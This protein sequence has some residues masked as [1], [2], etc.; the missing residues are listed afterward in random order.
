MMAPQVMQ[1]GASPI[2]YMD[3]MA[4]AAWMKLRSGGRVRESGA[5]EFGASVPLRAARSGAIPCCGA[6]RS[7][8][9]K[10]SGIRDKGSARLVGWRAAVDGMTVLSGALTVPVTGM[11]WLPNSRAGAEADSSAS[12]R[13]DKAGAAALAPR[14]LRLKRESWWPERKRSCI[15]RKR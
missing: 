15:Q 13:N 6:R 11:D 14:D 3:F 8:N 2:S 7:L 12:L 1:E 4:S 10:G 5:R 9:C